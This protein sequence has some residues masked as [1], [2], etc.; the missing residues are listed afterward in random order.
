[1]TSNPEDKM[2]AKATDP[3]CTSPGCHYVPSSYADYVAHLEGEHPEGG[4][5]R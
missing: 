5:V 1:M 2:L 3:E 4:L